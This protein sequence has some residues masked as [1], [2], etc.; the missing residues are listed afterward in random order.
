M[1]AI[2]KDYV[3]ESLAAY[4]ALLNRYLVAKIITGIETSKKLETAEPR[5]RIAVTAPPHGT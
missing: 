4:P 5:K 2:P 3:S 1:A